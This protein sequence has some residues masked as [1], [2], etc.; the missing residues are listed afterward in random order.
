[1]V[2][3]PNKDGVE[4]MIIQTGASFSDQVGCILRTE[5]VPGSR[6]EGIEIRTSR[7]NRVNFKM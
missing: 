3:K 6:K 7:E 1:M 2:T 4:K 5:N